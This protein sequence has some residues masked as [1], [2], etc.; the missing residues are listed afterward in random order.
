MDHCRICGKVAELYTAP[1]GA[2]VCDGCLGICKR[3]LLESLRGASDA[4][5]LQAILLAIE[6]LET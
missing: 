2:M 5:T 3:I 4:D 1:G 6:E